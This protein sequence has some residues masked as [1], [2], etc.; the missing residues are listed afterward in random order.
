MITASGAISANRLEA[1]EAFDE[2]KVGVKGLVDGGA[3][4]I[5]FFFRQTNRSVNPSPRHLSVPVVDLSL[6][7]D[8]A[9][10]AILSAAR[11]WGFFQ[12][13]NYA[14]PIPLVRRALSAVRS[15]HE[16]P[17]ADRSRFYTRKTESG[18]SYFSN[19]DLFLSSA[20]SWRDTLQIKTSPTPPN[21]ERIPAVCREELLEWDAAATELARMVMG[22]LAEGM[23]VE[24]ERLEMMTCLEGRVI[25]GHYYPPC[26]EPEATAGV[27][28]HTDPAVLT[29]LLQDEIGGLQIRKEGDDGEFCWVDV[30]PAPGAIVV[31]VGDLLQMISNDEYKSVE[32]RVL[33]NS[34]EDARVS[35]AMFFNPS[36]SEDSDIYG[37]LQELPHILLLPH[38]QAISISTVASFSKSNLFVSHLRDKRIRQRNSQ[39]S[40]GFEP[41]SKLCD[42]R[43]QYY[44]ATH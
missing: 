20:A 31:N 24:K 18:V 12:L 15:F 32:H 29:L 34:H 44:L 23:G 13:L 5:P 26:P 38:S 14:L 25:V 22:I 40:D 10:S 30:N 4:T 7:R 19:I 36:K 9:V 16:L 27:V 37:P 21:P 8:V 41:P 43:R 42:L 2:S 1:L 39:P 17:A 6:P 11:Q 33:A 3:T 35:I 28:Q